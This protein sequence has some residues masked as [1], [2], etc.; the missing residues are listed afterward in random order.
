MVL[1]VQPMSS[2]ATPGHDQPDQRAGGGHPVVG[3]GAPGSVG[4]PAQR[5]GPDGQP[6]GGLGGVPAERGQLG[7]QRGQP[8][9]LVAA[10]VGDA[11]QLRRAVG[12]R[13]Q[14]GDGRGELADVVQVDV[15]PGE[16][17]GTGHGDAVRPGSDGR[18]ELFEHAQ[19]G[20]ARLGGTRP[21]SPARDPPAGDRRGGQEHRGVGQ[22]GLDH[23][24]PREDR[25][26]RY[27][28]GVRLAVVH[29]DPGGAQHVDG[30]L[31]VRQ[32]RHRLAVVDH[33]QALVVGRP[34]QQQ[35]GHELR[36]AGRVQH[37][38]GRRPAHRCRAA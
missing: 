21:A 9:G 14:G 38:L 32:G 7:G 22:V 28:P 25:G 4:A 36:G 16:P 37:H 24:V 13:G 30:H 18:A 20:H 29:V 12:Q 3:V 6:V 17:V 26:G 27:P 31:D 23:P 1:S 2:T 15:D 8:V 33:R 11:A 5:P 35:A 34:G 10:Q 19:D